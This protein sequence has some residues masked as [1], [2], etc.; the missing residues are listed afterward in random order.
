VLVS[1]ALLTLGFASVLIIVFISVRSAIISI[2]R[3][4]LA[5]SDVR[6]GLYQ[7]LIISLVVAAATGLSAYL[8]LT[9]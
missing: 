6:G 9:F 8:I 5:A 7:V 2:G 1:T 3:N 4:P